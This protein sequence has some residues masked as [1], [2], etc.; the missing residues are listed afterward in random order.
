ME[1]KWMIMAAVGLGL[2]ACAQGTDSSQ[3][4]SSGAAA[5]QGPGYCESAPPEDPT[6]ADRWN[7][8][9]FPDR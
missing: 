2:G 7:E 5:D 9:C 6:E 4:A 1:R 3:F 8:L